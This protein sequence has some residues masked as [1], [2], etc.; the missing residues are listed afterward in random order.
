MKK[1]KE[2]KKKTNKKM[3]KKNYKNVSKATKAD[4][5]HYR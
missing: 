1:K 3:S 5:L 2:N 4:L